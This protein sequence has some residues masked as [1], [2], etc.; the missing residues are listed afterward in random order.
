VVFFVKNIL[1]NILVNFTPVG[2]CRL[3]CW[4]EGEEFK[5][6]TSGRKSLWNHPNIMGIFWTFKSESILFE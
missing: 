6:E 5:N 1:V 4:I 3:K 2:D